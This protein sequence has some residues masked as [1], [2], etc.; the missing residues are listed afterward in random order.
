MNPT[1]PP[2]FGGDVQPRSTAPTA[3][4][5]VLVV[6]RVI[7]IICGWLAVFLL[8]FIGYLTLPAIVLSVFLAAYTGYELVV[9][10][11][12]RSRARIG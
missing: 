1:L 12:R 2:A 11:R 9:R 8:T 5:A 3:L 7:V 6:A 4:T 10:R